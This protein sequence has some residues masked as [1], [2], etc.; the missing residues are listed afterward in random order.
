MSWG[1]VPPAREEG[2]GV[3][4]MGAG[5]HL[6]FC[7]FPWRTWD[8]P[9]SW[10]IPELGD[11]RGLNGGQGGDAIG[12]A[13]YTWTP[14]LA[15][16]RAPGQVRA[17]G[18]GGRH[19]RCE[20]LSLR[21]AQQH[22]ASIGAGSKPASGTG[23]RTGGSWGGSLTS[24]GTTEKQAKALGGG[25]GLQVTLAPS[26]T[27]PLQPG[28]AWSCDLN[29]RWQPRTEADTDQ[30]EGGGG[31]EWVLKF[32]EPQDPHS[33]SE[34]GLDGQPRE[35]PSTQSKSPPDRAAGAPWAA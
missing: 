26:L 20:G 8:D 12:R 28:C 11:L 23:R 33:A 21:L 24:A 5:P 10:A 22:E 2:S 13:E 29:A 27:C 1:G 7:P 35:W 19:S 6:L 31:E 15:L 4:S 32:R 16:A 3:A 18:S 25:L 17:G 34:P 9:T 14:P 30:G